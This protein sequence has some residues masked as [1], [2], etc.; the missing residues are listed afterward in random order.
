MSLPD[1][2]ARQDCLDL[3]RHVLA[4]A[5]AG[6]GKTGLL[7]QRMLAALATV[8]QPEQVIA[9]TFTRKAAAEI[10]HRVLE[11]LRDAREGKT[12]SDDFEAQCH[13]L[14]ASV[15][16]HDAELGWQLTRH[17]QRIMALTIDGF[18]SRIA[19]E[20]PLLSS[21]GGRTAI[22]DDDYSLYEQAVLNL[23]NELE[24]ADAP[25][26]LKQAAANWLRCAN[27]RVDQL[28][29]PLTHLLAR[30][31]QWGEAVMRGADYWATRENE[32]LET[33]HA[34]AQRRFS[35]MLGQQS[36]DE[37]IQIAAQA[38]PHSEL[39]EWAN[40]LKSWPTYGLAE[41]LVHRE[42]ARLILTAAG[43]LR[44]PGGID[45]RAGFPPQSP[46]KEVFKSWL[47]ELQDDGPLEDA[48]ATLAA[49]PGCLPPDAMRLL[50]DDLL[51]LLR[52]LLGHLQAVM[53]LRGE[54]DFA[55]IALAAQAALQPEEDQYGEAL[56]RRDE[57]IRHLLVDEMQDTS[58]SQIRLLRLLTQN[59]QPGDGR[60]L[61]LVGDPQQSIYAFR[62]AEVRLFQ[63]LIDHQKLTDNVA[64]HC[65]ELSANF[66]SA[67]EVVDWFNDCFKAIFPSEQNAAAGDILYSPSVAQRT[68]NDN[69]GVQIHPLPARARE[70]EANAVAER[71]AQLQQD[72]PQARIALLAKARTHLPHILEALRKRDIH[73]AGQDID[74]L[75]ALPVVRDLVA[76]AKALWHSQDALSW[77]VM[78]RA[79]WVGLSW[80]D[81]LA[82]S[83]GRRDWSWQRRLTEYETAPNLSEEGNQRVKR[84]LNA[85]AAVQAADHLRPQLPDRVE[86]LWTQL[87]G[88]ACIDSH[89]LA[90]ARRCLQLL[91]R[92]C[93]GG[94]LAD[95]QALNR[96]INNLYATP[97]AG[98]VE[99]MTIHK[100]KGLEF[101]HVILVGCGRKPRSDDK[102]LL[103]LRETEHGELLVPRPPEHWPDEDSEVARGLYDYIHELEKKARNSELLR[104]LYVAITRAKCTL[105]VY[106]GADVDEKK[107]FNPPKGS[108]ADLLRPV[109]EPLFS[110]QAFVEE[111]AKIEGEIPRAERI[112]LGFT[113]PEEERL[114]Q[115]REI[116]KLLPSEKVLSAGE[117]KHQQESDNIYAILVGILYHQAME[118]I[119]TDG[120]ES[121]QQKAAE[122]PLSLAAGF[123][124]MGLPEPRVGEAVERVLALVQKTLNGDKGQWLIKP[125]EWAA[126]EYQLAGYQ[127]GEWISASIDRCFVDDDE[128]L[129]VIDYK[130]SDQSVSDA[131]LESWL[132][133]RREHYRPQVESY[134]SLMS[135]MHQNKTI[136][137]ALYFPEW[138]ELVEY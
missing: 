136:R 91:R 137:S 69:A 94:E 49:L 120:L 20:L 84:F 104:L 63:E 97:V 38:A 121:W 113:L 17:P 50:R 46:A 23:F 26:A 138:D 74:A 41:G 79:P 89:D 35:E 37:L 96:A 82:L 99:V 27:N 122:Y 48:A 19:G 124:R 129:W 80:A 61:F 106:V 132:N 21:L 71:I 92:H 25:V 81:M 58:A 107:G 114:Y 44:K 95:L 70:A 87:G 6:S 115:P 126:A 22:T 16:E 62:K 36:R 12:P 31:D 30:R 110:E 29:E 66:R 73:F 76:A 118:K 100:A 83:T 67:P 119:C 111:T 9:I 112:D 54:A 52:Q 98:D 134:A 127:N 123:R 128:T 15:L 130:T 8:K 77:A 33:L 78:L 72:N 86:A 10:Q 3:G 56:L 45:K 59:W 28:I 108:F 101:D 90:D 64:L 43:T 40:E 2:Q 93:R 42:L 131:E 133:Q 4:I 24:S 117:D 65:V 105:D 32:L 51:I 39:L 102:P 68:A 11:L 13:R 55:Q 53:G 5:P 47:A 34:K 109:I 135:S 75:T 14:A 88:P 18:N 57:Q 103:H 1:F 85:L 116:R 60:S 7:V 125:R